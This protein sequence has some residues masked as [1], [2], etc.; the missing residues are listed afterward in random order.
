MLQTD[1]LSILK[2]GANVF[3]TGEPG[4]GK[5]H[6]VNEYVAWLRA[7]GI[8]PALAASTGIAATHIGGQTIHSWSGIGIAERLTPELL[9][10]VTSKE[11]VVK[12]LQ[13]TQ[14][15]ILDEVSML[16]GDVLSMVDAVT[17][18]ARHREEAFGG[19]QV[20]FVGDFFQLPPVAK[21]SGSAAFAFESSSWR[22]ANP[23]V[24]YLSEQHRHE[25]PH[26]V[27]ILSAMRRGEADHADVSRIMTREVSAEDIEDGTPQLFTH[28]A[29]VDRLNE[30]RLAALPGTA[31]RFRMEATGAP[32]VAEGLKRGCLSPETLVLKEGAVVMA[33]KNN[34]AV[35]YVNG[36][37]GV[38]VGFER[39]TNYPL[40]ETRDGRTLS[41]IPAEWAIEEGGKVKAKVSQIPLRLAWAVTVHKSQGQSLDMAAIDLS[42]AFEYGQ[43]YVALSRVR[44]LS[45]LYL[46]G[47]SEQALLVHPTVAAFDTELRDA[48]SVAEAAFAALDASGERAEM[49]QA[50]VRAC[51]GSLVAGAPKPPKRSTY[52]ETLTRIEA[53]VSI[54]DI[55][56]DRGLMFGTIVD[57]VA[58]LIASDRVTPD[59]I[60]PLLDAPLRD[61]LPEIH[62]VFE[63]IGTK[64]L[65]AVHTRLKGKYSYDELTLARAL[66]PA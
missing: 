16:S 1:A 17:R 61:A 24:C 26:L 47:W 18:A 9:D 39:G 60:M 8:E 49:E 52:D 27:S 29:D 14:V 34:P 50:F 22:A 57:H 23:V 6:T 59:T 37:I 48:S 66:S 41:F 40:V 33:T 42:R 46:L 32:T 5:T 62:R 10:T 44:S 25:D 28:N 63:K 3:L 15:L 7:R 65:T 35:G 11:H 38:V 13:K 55:A 51:G 31:H 21:R 45:G 19:M 4:S 30:E 64:Q 58:K 56:S 12:R 36:T 43:G 54:A 2:T 53:G 20:V